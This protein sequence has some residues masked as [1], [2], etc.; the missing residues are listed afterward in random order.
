MQI[1]CYN[2]HRPFALSKEGV[3]DALDEIVAGDLSHFDVHCPH[4]G[5]VNRASRKELLRAAPDWSQEKQITQEE[6]TTSG[7]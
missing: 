3:H 1:R 7:E 6:N 2:C 4:C 5:R